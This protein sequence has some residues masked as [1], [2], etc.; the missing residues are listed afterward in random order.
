[1]NCINNIIKE[2]KT[3]TYNVKQNEIPLCVFCRND[4]ELKKLD[5]DK[6]E[7]AY[8]CGYCEKKIKMEKSKCL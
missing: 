2:E 3:P 7:I 8:Y 6:G 4:I 5:K 1:M